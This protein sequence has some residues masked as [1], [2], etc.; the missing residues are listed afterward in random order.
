MIPVCIEKPEPWVCR[1]RHVKISFFKKSGSIFFKS[2]LG[3]EVGPTLLMPWCFSRA[4]M[5]SPSCSLEAADVID[6]MILVEK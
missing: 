2:V 5:I 6:W 4:N 1:P 3:E